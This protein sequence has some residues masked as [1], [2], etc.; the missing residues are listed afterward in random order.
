MTPHILH[1]LRR[2]SE[3]HFSRLKLALLLPTATT[4]EELGRETWVHHRFGTVASSEDLQRI[5]ASTASEALL[6]LPDGERES[7]SLA[8]AS[9]GYLTLRRINPTIDITIAMAGKAYPRLKKFSHML[10]IGWDKRQGGAP[11]PTTLS[12]I[13]FRASSLSNAIVHEDF[14][15]ILQQL[16]TPPQAGAS[17]LQ[18]AEWSGEVRYDSA[19]WLLASA[20]AQRPLRQLLPSLALRG[21]TLLALIDDRQQIQPI[22]SLKRG[23]GVGF[24]VIGVIGV[25]ISNNALC[26]ELAYELRQEAVDLPQV[27]APLPLSAQR[28]SRELRLLIIGWAGGVP[29]L[30]KN[31]SS[32]YQSIQLTIIDHQDGGEC[33]AHQHYLQSWLAAEEPAMQERVTMQMVA[34]NMSDMELLAPHL[35]SCDVA[36]LAAP[37]S[38]DCAGF[39]HITTILSHLVAIA[40]DLTAP[41][42]IITLMHDEVQAERLQQELDHAA[43][44]V[45]IDVMVP[46]ALYGSYIAHHLYHRHSAESESSR[47]INR[48]LHQAI[49]DLMI[50]DSAH[51]L[52]SIQLLEA[53]DEL[54]EQA[55]L[56]FQQLFDQQRIWI[57]YRL[58]SGISVAP[59]P[60]AQLLQ[61]L[62]PQPSSFVSARQQRLLINPFGNPLT[63]QEWSHHRLHIS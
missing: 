25:A 2:L 23:G 40:D 17:A 27:V 42:R 51:E 47:Q 50:N 6:I 61:R 10:Q 52:F 19:G 22:Y 8:S 37:S 58:D 57:G 36:L 56:L 55:E 1:Q 28:G 30:L 9:F 26:G 63:A 5:S 60:T 13:D 14:T 31:L 39:S 41:P 53:E 15:L 38:I 33:Q 54:P 35:G 62:F 11:L 4:P 24:K 3:H 43:S 32:E 29:K 16:L 12:E 45:E 48:A 7:T 20:A 46:D 18:A 21:V 34:W 49:N 59:P 44:A